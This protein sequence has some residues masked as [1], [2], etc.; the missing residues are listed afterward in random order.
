[1]FGFKVMFFIWTQAQH[2]LSCR[3]LPAL[4][5]CINAWQPH[6]TMLDHG[7]SFSPPVLPTCVANPSHT[8]SKLYC[9]PALFSEL[10]RVM[11]LTGDGAAVSKVHEGLSPSASLGG[12]TRTRTRTL[13]RG[14]SGLA[15]PRGCTDSWPA[16]QPITTV[17]DI[18]VISASCAQDN[19][20]PLCCVHQ[21]A[22][23]R[24]ESAQP[25]HQCMQPLPT[26]LS[27]SQTSDSVWLSGRPVY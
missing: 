22:V 16:T 19:S 15:M 11:E 21:M 8:E 12:L 27:G 23:G 18:P 10:P 17:P 9:L 1:M 2:S 14:C 26:P 4:C 7:A 3:L 5:S 25:L 13:L 20:G 6:K 24:S